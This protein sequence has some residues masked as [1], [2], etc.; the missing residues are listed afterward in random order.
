M[1]PCDFFGFWPGLVAVG[2]L[3]AQ[4]P[5]ATG[6]V[7]DWVVRKL[8]KLLRQPYQPVSFMGWHDCSLCGDNHS[9]ANLWLPGEGCIYV[10]P[11]GILHYILAHDYAPPEPFLEAIRQCPSMGSAGY[12]ER[13]RDNGFRTREEYEAD[14]GGLYFTISGPRRGGLAF[15]L[16]SQSGNSYE[17]GANFIVY[18]SL[19][20]LAEALLRLLAGRSPQEVRWFVGAGEYRFLFAL[21]GEQVHLRVLECANDQAADG[22]LGFEHE[23][24]LRGIARTFHRA[25]L[26]LEP[27]YSAAE[28]WDRPFPTERVRQLGE[29]FGQMTPPE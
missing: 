26:R 9:Y 21:E 11:E 7:E 20:D 10:A 6:V 14:N 24:Q 28:W 22:E 17:G 13:L 29:A 15:R 25:L 4:H 1:A 16:A 18:D 27:H 2:W 3:E 23:G 19:T 12:H 8:A 5:F